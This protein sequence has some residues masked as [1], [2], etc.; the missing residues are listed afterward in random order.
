MLSPCG[1]V[2]KVVDKFLKQQY[3]MSKGKGKASNGYAQ[4]II[5]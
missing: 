2:K 1:I 3:N 4:R 5:L